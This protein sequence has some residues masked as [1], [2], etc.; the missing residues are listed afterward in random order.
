MDVTKCFAIVCIVF[1]YKFSLE[2][3]EKK[4]TAIL[5]IQFHI[6]HYVSKNA[7]AIN[8]QMLTIAI[9]NQQ[10]FRYRKF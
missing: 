7:F 9:T 3:T 10:F 5:L 8:L 1:M 4:Y 2:L 6:Y